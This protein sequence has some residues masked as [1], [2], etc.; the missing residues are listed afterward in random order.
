MRQSIID[1][2]PNQQRVTEEEVFNDV[3]KDTIVQSKKEYDDIDRKKNEE[4]IAK[5]KNDPAALQ[6]KIENIFSTK[7]AVVSKKKLAPLT[8]A[9][10]SKNAGKKDLTLVKAPI[11][12]GPGQ[13]DATNAYAAR[14]SILGK[15]PADTNSEV[16][17]LD[18][19]NFK[20]DVANPSY[21]PRLLR[22][23]K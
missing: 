4:E 5:I 13:G 15:N 8:F 10:N 14:D 21:N 9:G 7:A 22:D 6:N 19:A 1:N 12:N 3:I 20:N 11:L 16:D 17:I 2:Q 18:D 23:E